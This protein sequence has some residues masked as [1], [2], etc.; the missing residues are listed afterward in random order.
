[1]LAEAGKLPVQVTTATLVTTCS[2]IATGI[3]EHPGRPNNIGFYCRRIA[4]GF[5]NSAANRYA[6]TTPAIA[7]IIVAGRW[8]NPKTPPKGVMAM[9]IATRSALTELAVSTRLG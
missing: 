4:R 6:S 2:Q 8:T 9:T 7:A 1:M 5:V 3:V